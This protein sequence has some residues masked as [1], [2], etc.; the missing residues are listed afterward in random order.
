M[1]AGDRTGVWRQAAGYGDA[2]TAAGGGSSTP[3]RC[4]KRWPATSRPKEFPT[5]RCE[6]AAV[7]RVVMSKAVDS[8]STRRQL[9]SILPSREPAGCTQTLDSRRGSLH[10]ELVAHR[11][12]RGRVSMSGAVR[13]SRCCC[14]WFSRWP[15]WP[16]RAGCYTSWSLAGGPGWL[17]MSRGP[18]TTQLTLY[19]A[20][21]VPFLTS[22]KHL[23][24]VSLM[25]MLPGCVLHCA[26]L[27]G[28]TSTTQR[29]RPCVDGG[30]G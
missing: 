11:Q 27:A 7:G 18:S 23:G 20:C 5:T 22:I 2:Q 14:P 4:E 30:R 16:C 25:L 9:C 28:Q 29:H 21:S 8:H 15:S 19:A 17:R 6:P 3:D 10:T 24:L 26:V 13:C 12:A 1:G